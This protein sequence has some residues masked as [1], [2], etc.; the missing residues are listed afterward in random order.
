MIK[1]LIVDDSIVFRTGIKQALTGQPEIQV[2]GSAIDG[3]HCLSQ[4]KELNPDVITL[5]L[6]MPKMDGLQT[7]QEIR[8]FNN[9][10]KIIVF[11]AHSEVGADKTF[12]ALGYGAQDFLPKSIVDADE[13]SVVGIRRIL[14]PKILQFK[15]ASPIKKTN[16]END[17][18][19]L[20]NKIKNF[21]PECICIGSSTG[22]PEALKNLFKVASLKLNLPVF[23]VQHMPP[24]FTKQLGQLLNSISDME[25]REG[26][27]GEEVQSNVVY[28]APGDYHMQIKLAGARKIVHLSQGEKENSVRPAVDVLFRSIAQSYN[29]KTCSFIL[30]G[31]GEDGLRGVRSLKEKNAPV[32]IESESSCVVYGMPGAISKAALQDGELDIKSIGKLITQVWG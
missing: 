13:D 7:I 31:M 28:I 5:D 25:V 27:H 12:K 29:G 18:N 3:E 9:D 14:V 11:S 19:I 17:L 32:I 2:V 15:T 10:I 24:M 16:Y 26:I 6:E 20:V 30:T 21:R 23:I 4:I 1:V 22:G 8:K